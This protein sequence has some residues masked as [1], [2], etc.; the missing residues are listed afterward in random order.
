[1]AQ[2]FT[3]SIRYGLPYVHRNRMK[4]D[5]FFFFVRIKTDNKKGARC[6][7]SEKKKMKRKK[8]KR[9]SLTHPCTQLNNFSS[10]DKRKIYSWPTVKN[11]LEFLLSKAIDK[12]RKI[13]NEL[14]FSSND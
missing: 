14:P 10:N 2:S 8:K 12:C 11:N 9:I 13:E 4:N 1:M 5:V 6:I 3:S 7:E